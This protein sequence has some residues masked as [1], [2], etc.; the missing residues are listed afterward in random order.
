MTAA[1]AP[2]A[3][4][5]TAAEIEFQKAKTIL[6]PLARD[7]K[8]EEDMLVKLIQEGFLSKKAFKLVRSCLEDL[9]VKMSTKDRCTQTAEILLKNGFAPKDWSEVQDCCT[10][11]TKELE[12]TSE[13]QAMV[14]IKRF[15]KDNAIDLPKRP[16]GRGQGNSF[17]AKMHK[18]MVEHANEGPEVLVE[19]LNAEG[20]SQS[21]INTQVRNFELGQEMAKAIAEAK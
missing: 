13:K 3:A 15:A 1:T 18:F 11:I 20:K 16:K 8:S 4:E 2:V 9:G 21:T 19:F 6:E 17:R 7:G 14:A 5:P 10:F 12:A